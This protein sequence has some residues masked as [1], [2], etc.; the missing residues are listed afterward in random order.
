MMGVEQMDISTLCAQIG[1]QF[2]MEKRVIDFAEKFDF[3]AV[4]QPLKEF[5]NYEKMN[6]ARKQLQA[7]L[8]DDEDHVKILACML[9]ASAD[10][11]DVY[12]R[13]GICDEIYFD[14]MRCYTRFLDETY[15]MTGRLYFDRAWWTVRQ[16]GGHLFRIGALEY[17]IEPVNDTTVLSIH[18]PSDADFS[19]PSVD[20]SLAAA[21]EFFSS[22][23]PQLENAE[24]RCRSWLLDRRLQGMLNRDSNIVR[25]QDR[26]A[27]IDEGEVDTEYYEWLFH[28]KSDEVKSFPENTLLQR[29]VKRYLLSGGAIRNTYGKLR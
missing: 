7:M 27:M 19:P 22:Y 24:Y 8:E 2:E 20:R 15:E 16:A 1:L 18:I 25:F 17:E 4:D 12:Q 5:K 3:S 13:R 23:S 9:K 14:T 10:L 28:T 26:F 21:K 11:Y 6:E 29:N